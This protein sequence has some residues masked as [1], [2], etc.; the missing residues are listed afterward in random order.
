[1]YELRKKGH[2][3]FLLFASAFALWVFGIFL[4]YSATHIHESGPLAGIYKQ[5][6]IW[7]AMALLIII[8]IISIPGRII[9]N[10]SYLFYGFSL[11]LLAMVLVS[12]IET[13]GAGRWIN[14]AGF[15][16]QP[17]EFAKIGLLL[18]LSKYLSEN[19]VSLYHIST[20]VIPGILILV[21][22]L[23]VL[24]Q[25]DL[26]TALVFILMALPM[27]YWAGLTLLEIFFI[28]S[29]A[30]SIA[31][32][33]IPLLL[34]Y[35]SESSWGIFE[36]VPWGIFFLALIAVLYI[37]RPP[38]FIWIGSILANIATTTV[39]TILWGSVLK[40]YQKMRIISFINPQ[41]DPFGAGYQVI[42]SKVAIGS[43][44]IWGKGYLQGTQ[45]R[46]SF[47]PEQHTDFIFSVLGEQFGLVGCSIVIL[48]FLVVIVRGLMLTHYVKNRFINLLATGCAAILGFHVFVNIAMTVGLMPVTGLPLPFLSY[49]GSFTITVAVLVGMLL[50]ARI[51]NQDF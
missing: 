44:H 47:L 37:T 14:V 46:L 16:I 18:A 5:Q 15:K 19:K 45:S 51:T 20:F 35:N 42:Q 48:L 34:S 9:F 26:G 10:A 41:E 27:F 43:G 11:V 49:G 28:I 12:G 22:F 39:V 31:L 7:V 1:M 33:G 13:K 2:F 23:L 25:P 3:D 4:V 36:S 50:N 6:I 38:I 21:P 30:I 24:K 29:P 32:A 17:S 40:D 8:M